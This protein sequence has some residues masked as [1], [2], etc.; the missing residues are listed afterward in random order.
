MRGVG[1]TQRI[2]GDD[3]SGKGRDS[4]RAIIGVHCEVDRVIGSNRPGERPT[5][6]EQ[7]RAQL[8][9][10]AN[11]LLILHNGQG[12][13]TALTDTGILHEP[14]IGRGQMRVGRA[15][16]TMRKNAGEDPSASHDDNPNDTNAQND[17]ARLSPWGTRG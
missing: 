5:S 11:R 13:E 10:T 7:S 2:L 17:P 14:L 3:R 12:K 1:P 15:T 6:G 9:P 4:V 16:T 8:L